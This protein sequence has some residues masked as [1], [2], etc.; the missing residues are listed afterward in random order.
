MIVARTCQAIRESATSECPWL[1]C[2]GV[3]PRLRNIPQVKA[4]LNDV[5]RIFIDEILVV[6]KE[7]AVC[8][9]CRPTRVSTFK[10]RSTAIKVASRNQWTMA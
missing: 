9:A 4:P 5:F 1:T 7:H 6:M 2:L 10:I 3:S 8:H